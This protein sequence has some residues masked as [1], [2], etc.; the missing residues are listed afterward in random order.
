M[1]IFILFP[2]FGVSEKQWEHK[3]ITKNN[4]YIKTK[5]NFLKKLKNLGKVYTYTPKIHD[6][7]GYYWTTADLDKTK[8]Y[9]SL[10]KKP[11]PMSLDDINIDKE[12]KR[13]Y[14]L[15][16]EKYKKEKLQF[17]PIGHSLG[18]HFALHFSNLYSSK[19]LKM[20]FLDASF[21]TSKLGNNLYKD[22]TELTKIKA[23]DISN[24]NLKLIF[25]NMVNNIKKERY[26]LNKK[27]NKYIDKMTYITFAYYYKIIKKELNGKIKVPL[28]SFRN[29]TFDTDEIK[30]NTKVNKKN[31]KRVT[32]EE[33]LFNLNDNKVTTHYLVNSTHFPFTEERYIDQIIDTI[34]KSI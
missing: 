11:V 21:I 17:V 7:M 32:E 1:I 20:I 14:K 26:E 18:S 3:I 27:V 13:I 22:D 2:G 33:E 15:L 12:C 10:F 16:T 25:N 34:K 30:N 5:I 9:S 6:I 31:M 4:K 29:I 28:I 19:C 23:K 8:K 24:D